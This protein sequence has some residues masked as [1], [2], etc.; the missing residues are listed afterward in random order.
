MLLKLRKIEFL[1]LLGSLMCHNAT[2]IFHLPHLTSLLS[3]RL[4]THVITSSTATIQLSAHF[5]SRIISRDLNRTKLKCHNNLLYWVE[6]IRDWAHVRSFP[7]PNSISSLGKPNWSTF[8]SK[9]SSTSA[10]F[11]STVDSVSS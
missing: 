10:F 6:A 1:T 8:A 2:S 9:I 3:A 11:H 7:D 5:F 4:S